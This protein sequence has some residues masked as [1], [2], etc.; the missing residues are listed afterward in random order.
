MP[1]EHVAISVTPQGREALRGLT[2]ALTGA[3]GRRVTMGEALVAAVRIAS[4]DVP[5]TLAVL[6]REEIEQ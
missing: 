3:A 2:Y 1:A 5:G 6:P 4:Q